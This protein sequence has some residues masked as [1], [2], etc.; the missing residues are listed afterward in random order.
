MAF[1]VDFEIERAFETACPFDRVFD[2]L[3]DVP[4]SVS[5]FP[6]V[7]SLVELGGERYRWEMEKIGLDRYHIQTVYACKYVSDRDK[8][9]VKWTPVKGEG[10]AEVSG[11]WTIKTLD[12]ARTRVK[13]ETK[14]TMSLPLPSLVRI[15][16][17]PVVR[18]EFTRLIDQYLQNLGRTF[19]R[20]ARKRKSG[21]KAK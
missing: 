17:A 18:A 5:H 15:V 4:R 2:V 1:Q 3:S 9:S 19:E 16:V 14:G 7:E 8:G 13:L 20:E 11:K 12:D 6:K 10:N 21:G